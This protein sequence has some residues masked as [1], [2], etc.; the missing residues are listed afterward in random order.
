MND[1]ASKLNVNYIVEGSVRIADENL[2]VTVQLFDNELDKTIWSE[3]YNNKLTGILNIQDKIAGSI[4]AQL[5]ATL[6]ITKSD[7]QATKRISTQN[8]E[9]YNLIQKAYKHI[10]NPIYSP[11]IISEKL[12]L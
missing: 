11:P 10:S 1:I 3:T 12:N 8:L 7:L 4:V 9:A 5:N 6:T 2:R